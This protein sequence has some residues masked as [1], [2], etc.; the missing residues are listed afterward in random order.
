[1]AH[2]RKSFA[3]LTDQERDHF[4]A[5]LIELKFAPAS[6]DQTF[7]VYDQFIAI[8]T[9]ATDVESGLNDGAPAN[10]G[11]RGPV[12]LPWHRE[13]L[14]RLQKGL[15]SVNSSVVLPYWDWTAHEATFSRLFTDSFIGSVPKVTPDEPVPVTSGYFGAEAPIDEAKPSWWPPKATGWK[16]PRELQPPWSSWSGTLHRRVGGRLGLPTRSYIDELLNLGS[17]RKFWFALESGFVFSVEGETEFA[18]PMHD[19]VHGWVGGHMSEE[20]VSPFDPIFPLNHAYVDYLWYCWQQDGHVGP[21]YYPKTS[22]W[23]G[24]GEKGE[25]PRGHLLK[26][27]MYPWVGDAKGYRTTRTNAKMFLPDTRNELPRR[28]IDVLDTLNLVHDSD[29]NYRYERPKV[30][31]GTVQKILDKLIVQWEHKWSRPAKLVEKHLN[32]QFGW[33]TRD[34]LRDGFARNNIRL[35]QPEMIGGESGESTNLIRI[36]RG[37]L[38]SFP[39]MPRNGPFLSEDEIDTIA[40]WI[41]DG[42]LDD[43]EVPAS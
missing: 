9:A 40:T 28:P 2:V 12:F 15:S 37:P 29:F 33:E 30:R 26:D 35:I 32:P 24:N 42:C 4:L 17:Y 38:R 8:H 31:F 18:R 25:I 22:D 11:H 6:E 10:M 14:L 43:S 16:L 13:F 7:S 1:M 19:Q 5:A 27:A 20:L 34:Q 41:D 36:L 39:Q 3:D 23:D 21:N